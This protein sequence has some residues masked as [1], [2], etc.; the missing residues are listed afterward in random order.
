MDIPVYHVYVKGDLIH[1]F[2]SA[3]TKRHKVNC[4]MHVYKAIF[5]IWSNIIHI[6]SGV[7]LT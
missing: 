3:T 5:A 7:Q 1:T 2:D 6:T 4:E